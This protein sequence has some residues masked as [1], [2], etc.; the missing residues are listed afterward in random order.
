MGAY[1][2]ALVARTGPDILTGAIRRYAGQEAQKGCTPT[3]W[4]E[5]VAL[6]SPY[7]PIIYRQESPGTGSTPEVH[8]ASPPAAE[9]LI[10]LTVWI[11]PRQNVAWNRCEQ[12]F[13]HLRHLTCRIGWEVVGNSAG[14]Y[15]HVLCHKLDVP[16][17]ET[18]FGGVFRECRLTPQGDN[19]LASMEPSQWRRAAFLD[20]YPPPPYSRLFTCPDQLAE[21]PYAAFVYALSKIPADSVGL[22]QVLLQPVRPDHN[23]HRNIQILT[24]MEYVVGQLQH[25]GIAQRYAQQT[26][27]IEMHMLTQR[28]ET[29]AHN[30]KPFFAVAFRI[31]AVGLEENEVFLAAASAF[32]NLYQQ[33]GCPLSAVGHQQYR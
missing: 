31:A 30:D 2:Q 22:C 33:G 14:I 8:L 18:A 9:D 29:K 28:M 1:E 6:E 26:P 24:D 3:L 32:A 11:S 17:I 5:P 4:T 12:F 10:R 23:W 19:L 13:K 15:L 25:M 27:S 21:S 16:L 20:F 7:Q